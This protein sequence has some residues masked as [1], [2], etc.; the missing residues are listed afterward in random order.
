[1]PAEALIITERRTLMR[2]LLQPF[3]DTWRRSFREV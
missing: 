2:Y 1:M 3:L